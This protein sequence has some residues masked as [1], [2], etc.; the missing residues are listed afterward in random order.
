MSK[1]CTKPIKRFYNVN[2]LSSATR[3]TFHD[4][5]I[6]PVT[7]LFK[8]YLIFLPFTHGI[9]YLYATHTFLPKCTMQ[10]IEAKMS[11]RHGFQS[12][13]SNRVASLDITTKD[14]LLPRRKTLKNAQKARP[15]LAIHSLRVTRVIKSDS[16]LK[17]SP[18]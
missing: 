3:N 18:N 15:H 5:L 12:D 9:Q 11:S 6:Y 1:K 14:D 17:G 16:Y 2:H 7:R 13:M 8:V 4:N 10:W